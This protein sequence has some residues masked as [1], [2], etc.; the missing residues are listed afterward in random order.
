MA[1]FDVQILSG[2][3]QLFHILLQT[4]YNILILLWE[5]FDWILFLFDALLEGVY[6]L[7]LALRLFGFVLHDLEF[8]FKQWVLIV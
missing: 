4:I 5:F 3:L 2:K 6:F 7:E 1:L 8:G